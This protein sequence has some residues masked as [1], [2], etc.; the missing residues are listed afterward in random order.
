[1]ELD[2]LF[3]I[4]QEFIMYLTA[5]APTTEQIQRHNLFESEKE[6]IN[7]TDYVDVKQSILEM[8]AK[9]TGVSVTEKRIQINREVR[10]TKIR[11]LEINLGYK[12]ET[13]SS[14]AQ[15]LADKYKRSLERLHTHQ[16]DPKEQTLRNIFDNP[17]ANEKK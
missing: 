14:K 10:Q 3:P 16:V 6:I 4:Q 2:N 7:V 13:V 8:Q 17:L 11:E 5:F 12:S 9:Q 15:S 1:M